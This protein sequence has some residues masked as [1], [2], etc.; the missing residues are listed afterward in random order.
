MPKCGAG[1]QRV[2]SK[3]STCATIKAQLYSCAI[4]VRDIA[5][6]RVDLSLKTV[7]LSRPIFGHFVN[8]LVFWFF[9]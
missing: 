7:Q 3:T 2:G 1:F 5:S 4:L 9:P 8:K 6:L